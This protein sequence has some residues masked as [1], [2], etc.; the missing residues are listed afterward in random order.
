MPQRRPGSRYKHIAFVAG[1]TASAQHA[2]R[3]LVRR[4]GDVTPER[5]DV[6]VALGGDGLMLTTLQRFMNSDRPIYGMHRGSIQSIHRYVDNH[7]RRTVAAPVR[8][9]RPGRRSVSGR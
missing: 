7:G 3:R 2:R 5:A 9:K 8:S 1:D 4:Y 6:I